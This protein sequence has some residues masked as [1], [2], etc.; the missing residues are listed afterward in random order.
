VATGVEPIEFESVEL[1]CPVLPSV[2]NGVMLVAVVVRLEEGAAVDPEFEVEIDVFGLSGLDCWVLE[3]GSEVVDAT[4]VGGEL[5]DSLLELDP[6]LLTVV[7]LGIPLSLEDTVEVGTPLEG[8]EAEGVLPGVDCETDDAGAPVAGVD[9]DTVL[10]ETD[11]D[12]GVAGPSVNEV[13]SDAAV[14]VIDCET[15]VAGTPTDEVE[16]DTELPEIVSNIDGVGTPEIEVESDMVLLELG[17]SVDDIGT[18]ETEVE[19]SE[20]LPESAGVS[21]GA[22]ELTLVG[23]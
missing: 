17:S 10:S 16:S 3:A 11:S 12:D 2:T 23:V 18:L 21:V 19:S 14:L 5:L 1:G 8:I 15:E 4:D 9:S 20:V 13:E 7:V 22:P 6:S